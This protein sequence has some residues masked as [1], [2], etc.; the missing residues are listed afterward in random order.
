MKNT[1]TKN[2]RLIL[3]LLV[4]WFLTT[5][6]VGLAPNALRFSFFGWEFTYWWGAQGALLI[7]LLLVWVYAYK[8]HQ[9]EKKPPKNT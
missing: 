2:K 7:Y 6:L 5:L 3:I 4:V 9:Y 8:M 1:W